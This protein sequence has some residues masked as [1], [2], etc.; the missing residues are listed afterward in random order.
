MTSA[1]ESV[2]GSEVAMEDL[3]EL[4]DAMRDGLK[5]HIKDRTHRLRS[6]KRC[7][8]G[9]AGARWLV[10]AGRAAD[11]AAAVALGN[12][13]L[14]AGLIHHVS[15]DK[16]F[17]SSD[18]LLYKFTADDDSG[19]VGDLSRAQS[20]VGSARSLPALGGGS[21]DG[22]APATPGRMTPATPEA[23]E[24]D[25]KA[26][27]SGGRPRSS[28][29]GGGGASGGG[30]HAH[31]ALLN[32]QVHGLN[33]KLERLA[34][35]HA[36]LA[37]DAARRLDAWEGAASEDL[38]EIRSAVSS[39]AASMAPTQR[40]V[41]AL[42]SQVAGLQAQLTSA[43][44][45]G[46]VQQLLITL[47]A[48]AI[49]TGWAPRALW[50][51]AAAAAA[52]VAAVLLGVGRGEEA[53]AQVLAGEAGAAAAAQRRAAALHGGSFGGGAAAAGGGG[54]LAAA[55]AAAARD[56]ARGG[57][58]GRGAGGFGSKDAPGLRVLATASA[59][60]EPAPPPMGEGAR[61]LLVGSVMAGKTIDETVPAPEDFQNWPDGNVIMR[62][63]PKSNDLAVT[64]VTRYESPVHVATPTPAHR[65]WEARQA[66]WSA[67]AAEADADDAAEAGARASEAGGG[68]VPAPGAGLPVNQYVIH[69]ES[70]L[71][72][73]KMMAYIKGLPSSHEPYFTGKKRR[74]VLMLQGRFKSPLKVDDVVT[75]QEFGRPYKNLRGC[76]LMEKVVL[77]FTKRV[78]TA[79]ETGDMTVQPYMLFPLLPLAHVVNVSLPGQ[80]PPLDQAEEDLRLWD[81]SLVD[82]NGNPMASD[83]RRRRF[84]R[85][86]HRR[87][88]TYTTDHVW[89]FVIWQ[90]VIDVAGYFLDLIVQ[91]YD[92]IQHLDG[93]PLQSMVK[94]KASGKYLF[95]LVYW[96]TKLIA[97]TERIRAAEAAAAAA[98]GGGGAQ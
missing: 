87:G 6:Y 81:P 25:G 14:Q 30:H 78:I 27:A 85:D 9:T 35:T 33:A 59:E 39:L 18:S 24:A 26:A 36:A 20:Q 65:S 43:R 45:L 48:L 66:R 10:S 77:A 74:S 12:A 94:D 69:F 21:A 97:E 63:T 92:M 49:G 75:G 56:D 76:W 98:A 67:A 16:T 80:E 84:M 3:K 61:K 51:L 93:Q 89:T 32:A 60:G 73:G 79:M 55:A 52:G 71:F 4:S 13:L 62:A 42:G 58:Q 64:R 88:R 44:A 11:E 95:H 5:P 29:S 57:D 83:A 72:V 17:K 7:F 34:A 47:A 2:L 70:D 19:A 8:T 90:Q 91:Q 28:A 82:S 1:K 54:A 40:Q 41:L 23:P 22:S 50:A 46:A 37:S 31:R 53:A 15:Y 68:W 96:N 38:R 86:V